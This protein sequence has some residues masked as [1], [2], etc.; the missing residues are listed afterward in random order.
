[1]KSNYKIRRLLLFIIVTIV[2]V[3]SIVLHPDMRQTTSP[4]PENATGEAK[5][6]LDTLEVKGRAPKTGYSRD[7]FGG[8]WTN[9]G[10]CDTRNIILH[11]DLTSVAENE[12]CQVVSGVLNDP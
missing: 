4:S 11:R 5:T 12:A 7:Q 8:G 1:M 6:V 2:L 3:V 10:G 9:I